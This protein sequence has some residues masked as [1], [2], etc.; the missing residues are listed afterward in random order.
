MLRRLLDKLPTGLF[1][2]IVL[3]VILWLT[4][5]PHPTGDV[6]IPLFPGAD[7]I[8]HALMFMGLTMAAILDLRKLRKWHYVPV[9]AACIV[10][11]ISTLTGVAIEL[12]QD[13]MDAGRSLEG[14]DIV[15][16]FIG[17]AI[18]AVLWYCPVFRAILTNGE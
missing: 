2:A 8:V 6:E 18:G 1:T 16:D 10:S 7:K 11:V 13:A 15:A 5:A 17:S 4:L 9:T 12:A 14:L 3:S